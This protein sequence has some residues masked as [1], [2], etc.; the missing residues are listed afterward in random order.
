MIP[1][2]IRAVGPVVLVLVLSTACAER[3]PTVAP[4]PGGDT[5][6]L[7]EEAVGLSPGRLD[8]LPPLA[9][10]PTPPGDP[11]DVPSGPAAY[12]G[13]PPVV[14][15]AIE[16]FLPIERD[17]NACLDCH[18]RG[19]PI[20]GEPTPVPGSHY[21]DLRGAPDTSG[22]DVAGARWVCTACHVPVTDAP[23]LVASEF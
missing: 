5:A 15:H 18:G 10:M 4:T 21:V 1:N 11:G 6:A 3:R 2:A 12:D 22:D 16:D 7:P 9:P 17:A 13:A 8:S 23:P 14:P 19:E 20:P